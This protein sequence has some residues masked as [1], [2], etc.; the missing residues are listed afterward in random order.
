MTGPRAVSPVNNQHILGE[1]AAIFTDMTET[2]LTALDQQ[3]ALL[4]EAQ[5]PEGSLTSNVLT[6]RQPSS[7]SNIGIS[8]TTPQTV[9]EIDNKYPDLHLP[10]V[11]KLQNK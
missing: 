5:K 11:K 6:P 3:M 4:G 2:M 7:S 8:K 9:S 10:V 1:G